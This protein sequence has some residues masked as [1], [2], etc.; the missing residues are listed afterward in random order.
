MGSPAL[1][2]FL[3]IAALTVAA[4]GA[5]EAQ[6]APE[7]AGAIAAA[8]ERCGDSGLAD[9]LARRYAGDPAFVEE[10]RFRR[11]TEPRDVPPRSCASNRELAQLLEAI[12]A[13]P[14]VDA[15]PGSDGEPQLNTMMRQVFSV[16]AG[17]A[18]ARSL[19]CGLGD[20]TDRLSDRFVGDAEFRE[21]F[22]VIQ[23][24][25]LDGPRALDCSAVELSA[26]NLV[27]VFQLLERD[28]HLPTRPRPRIHC[29]L[30]GLRVT[31]PMSSDDCRERG[32]RPYDAFT[33]VEEDYTPDQERQRPLG[34]VGRP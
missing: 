21:A 33:R 8:A 26:R 32:G 31:T 5:L 10:L 17:A 9:E 6:V 16:R 12:G 2:R 23:Q 19:S 28:I 18:A 30:P 4:P 1:C 20:L 27:V 25:L 22:L 13:R 34:T 29:L 3:T 7:T 14:G 15:S 24:K 11:A